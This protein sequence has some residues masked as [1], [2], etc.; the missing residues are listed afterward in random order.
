MVNVQRDDGDTGKPVFF[1]G[2]RAA[3]ALFSRHSQA[4][5]MQA[6]C[7]LVCVQINK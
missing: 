5:G 7:P 3:S 1:F 4:L 6:Y 2:L